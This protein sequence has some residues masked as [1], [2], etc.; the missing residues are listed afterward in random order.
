M[1]LDSDANS[2]QD[3]LDFPWHQRHMRKHMHPHRPTPTHSLEA[4]M[5][6]RKKAPT[7]TEIT[8]LLRVAN[9][10]IEIF[11]YLFELFEYCLYSKQFN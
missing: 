6:L 2:N 8:F 5:P 7:V 11:E 4:G 10:F 9:C 3:E 1:G